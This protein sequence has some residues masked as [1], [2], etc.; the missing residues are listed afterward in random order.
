VSPEARFFR[1]PVLLEDAE[2][3]MV[4][5]GAKGRQRVQHV[6]VLKLGL[7]TAAESLT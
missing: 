1:V 3:D 6:V 7:T 4:R 2:V 5:G